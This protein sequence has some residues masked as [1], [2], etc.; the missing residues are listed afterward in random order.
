ML[1]SLL[2]GGSSLPIRSVCARCLQ[3][4]IL[5]DW[6]RA[7]SLQVQ[8][9]SLTHTHRATRF[10][11]TDRLS[12]QS[13]F[14][15]LLSPSPLYANYYIVRLG[16]SYHFYVVCLRKDTRGGGGTACAVELHSNEMHG[17]VDR[18]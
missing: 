13:H 9:L 7:E 16:F 2:G 4:P 10:R 14:N 1:K 15:I 17:W 8:R 6:Q 3:Y 12:D 18:A 11:S 5:R